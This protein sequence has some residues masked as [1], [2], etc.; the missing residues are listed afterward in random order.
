MEPKIEFGKQLIMKSP[1]RMHVPFTINRG[2][3]PVGGVFNVAMG[4]VEMVPGQ[5]GLVSDELQHLHREF[6]ELFR[7]NWFDVI[8]YPPPGGP[9]QKLRTYP[10]QW[11]EVAA[12]HWQAPQEKSKAVRFEW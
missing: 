12:S 8:G 9:L 7:A 3:R 2:S 1:N 6:L 10:A 5:A 11:V 4:V